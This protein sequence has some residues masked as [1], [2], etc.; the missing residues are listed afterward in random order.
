[1]VS[2]VFQFNQVLEQC[3]QE[4]KTMNVL[5][6]SEIS[7]IEDLMTVTKINSRLIIRNFQ[8]HVLKDELVL[9]ILKNNVKY[10]VEYNIDTLSK[11]SDV[12]QKESI[13]IK[14]FQITLR[15]LMDDI[16]KASTIRIILLYIQKMCYYAYMDLDINPVEKIRSLLSQN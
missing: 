6:H 15:K 1:M 12:I 10:F 13:M 16:D 7:R 8:I 4:L 14:Q 9:N 11:E 5:N 2:S 3:I